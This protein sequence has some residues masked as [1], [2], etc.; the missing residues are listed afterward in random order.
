MEYCQGGSLQDLINER[1]STKTP[2]SEQYIWSILFQLASALLYCHLGLQADDTGRVSSDRRNIA[3]W[4]PVLHRDI[5]P[6]NIFLLSHSENALDCVR[7]GDFGLGY[8]LQNDTAPETYAGTAQYLAPEINRTST[9]SIHWTEHCDIFSLGCMVYA[10]C[11]FKPPFDYHME[12]DLEAYEPL[13]ERYSDQ[14]RACIAS[15][16]SYYPQT[17]PNALRL[18]QQSQQRIISSR[19]RDLKATIPV[20]V[21]DDPVTQPSTSSRSLA[22]SKKRKKRKKNAIK[23]TLLTY[24]VSQT[25]ALP[26]VPADLALPTGETL[27][28]PNSILRE[29]VVKGD[30][31]LTKKALE[32]EGANPNATI[33]DPSH[34]PMFSLATDGH[35]DQVAKLLI[36]AGADVN[37]GSGNKSKPLY[38]AAKHNRLDFLRILLEKRVSGNESDAIKI[39]SDENVSIDE[40][41]VICTLLEKGVSVDEIDELGRTALSYAAER[42]YSKATQLLL[43]EDANPN[44][45]DFDMR[46]PLHWAALKGHYDVVSILVGYGAERSIID[47]AGLTAEALAKEAGESLVAH[48]LSHGA[49]LLDQ[50]SKKSESD[51]DKEIM[52]RHLKK[53]SKN[54]QLLTPA[55]E[56]LIPI[57]SNDEAKQKE[58]DQRSKQKK[59]WKTGMPL[60]AISTY[61][62]YY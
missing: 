31:D 53:F 60:A 48:M 41:D 43:R 44:I 11:T 50:D 47:A 7:L 62:Y 4:N 58:I 25:M 27:N 21:A 3:Q 19:A 2:I 22:K 42:G 52:L 36:D 1:I 39:F 26:S 55:P 37:Q 9:R 59:C 29:A 6:G 35:H 8:V 40:T 34:I 61:N 13:P 54:F 24:E 20:V 57:L 46:T 30:V 23:S 18:F 15:C 49:S 32:M 16:L 17:R 5:K 56:D 28:L 14:L 38:H 10:L 51:L 45:Q 12:T 33:N